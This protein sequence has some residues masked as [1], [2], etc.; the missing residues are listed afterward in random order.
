MQPGGSGKFPRKKKEP[1]KESYQNINQSSV[2]RKNFQ[3]A[4]YPVI[5]LFDLVRFIAFYL[6]LLL[7]L[8]FNIVI[9]VIPGERISVLMTNRGDRRIQFD[10][11]NESPLTKQ[12]RHHR[13]AFEL[14]SKA[15]KLDEEDKG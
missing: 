6:W 3:I 10:D 2:H 7:S 13:R 5:A 11:D 12:K 1:P 14:I 8:T 9:K 4:A 15:L